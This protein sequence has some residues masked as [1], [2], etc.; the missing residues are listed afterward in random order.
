MGRHHR[1]LAAAFAWTAGPG[2]ASRPVPDPG[3]PGRPPRR[4]PGPWN[5]RRRPRRRALRQRPGASGP[6]ELDERP[7][8]RRASRRLQKAAVLQS[9]EPCAGLGHRVDVEVPAQPHGVPAPQWVSGRPTRRRS[10]RSTA[11]IPRRTGRRSGGRTA[12]PMDDEVGSQQPAQ[13]GHR[14]NLRRPVPARPT[15]ARYAARRRRRGPPVRGGLR[16]RCAR[17]R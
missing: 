14:R 1:D 5:G 17:R 8:R 16:H 4:A 7:N 13:P 2:S 9:H 12:D 6:G 10:G 11:A 15:T 3:R